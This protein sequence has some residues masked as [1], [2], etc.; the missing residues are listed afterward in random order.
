VWSPS[1]LDLLASPDLDLDL[2]IAMNPMSSLQPGLPTTIVERF[3]RRIRRSSGRRLGR[4]AKRFAE[5]GT[6]LLLIQPGEEDLDAMGIN[7]MDPTRRSDVL[8]TSLATSAR[9]LLEPDAQSVIRRLR[10]VDAVA[11]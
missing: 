8:E 3:E 4:E 6:E 10:S 2:V 5:K 9:R 11:G 7:L 1:N